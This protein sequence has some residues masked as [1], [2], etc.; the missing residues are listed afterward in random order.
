[1]QLGGGRGPVGESG[2]NCANGCGL[3]GE[4]ELQPA[5]YA[6]HR[7]PLRQVGERERKRGEDVEPDF[8]MKIDR[9]RA[10]VQILA[11][12]RVGNDVALRFARGA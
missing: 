7:Q 9:G 4:V 1:M 3:R 12:R 8:T 5:L 11:K 6:L 2:V 10:D